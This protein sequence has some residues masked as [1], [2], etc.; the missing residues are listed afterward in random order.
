[1]G[2]QFGLIILIGIELSCWFESSLKRG[3][4]SALIGGIIGALI[5]G[6]RTGL[7]G[8]LSFGLTGGLVVGVI[9]GV[10]IG[11][12]T[13]ISPVETMSWQWRQFWK[14]AILGSKIGLIVG[15]IFG[16]AIVLIFVLSSWLGK[17]FVLRNSAID[18]LEVAL[19]LGL[20]TGISGGLLLW[21]IS[22]I[23]SGL[24]GGMTDAVRVD[25][26]S[27]NQGIT[28]S[29][30]NAVLST[31]VVGLIAWLIVGLIIGLI[32]EL[33]TGLIV[34]SIIG[35]T[36]GVSGGLNR[37]GSA[38]IKHYSLRLILWMKGYTPFRFIKFLDHCAKL[39]LL[40]KVGGGYIFIHRMLL[41]HFAIM[42]LKSTKAKK[43]N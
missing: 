39:I 33:N 1:L 32:S 11:P 10:G 4:I 16:L 36:L 23:V 5:V 19:I 22:G 35:L 27:P 26:A 21:L 34:G 9:S 24:L 37:G 31:F 28:L 2:L 8:G 3:F 30:K 12:L 15:L 18:N 29:L 14:K 13:V 42:E 43:S 41:E 17:P 38:V 40:K 7:Q 6:L 25:K 20:I